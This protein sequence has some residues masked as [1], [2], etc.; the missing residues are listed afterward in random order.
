ML[1]GTCLRDGPTIIVL[2]CGGDKSTLVKDIKM[3]KRLADEWS[4]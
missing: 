1:N 3:A 2:L 4:E